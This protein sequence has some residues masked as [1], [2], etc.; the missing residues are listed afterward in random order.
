M[1]NQKQNIA[2]GVRIYQANTTRKQ[3]G[4]GDKGFDYNTIVTDKYPTELDFKTNNLAI[5][6]ENQFKLT[7]KFSITP[8]L[9]YENIISDIKGRLTMSGT[10][11]VN[12][13]PN[14]TTRS[15]ILGGLGLAYKLESTDFYANISQAF[16]PVLFS[17]ITPPATTDVIDPNLKDANGF[18]ADFG[19]R[20]S[21]NNYLTFDI[22]AFYIQYND[23]I[24]I[25]RQFVNNDSNKGTYQLRTNLG[26]SSNKGLEA[27]FNFNIFKAIKVNKKFGDLNLFSTMAFINATY[28][29]FKITT[30]SGSEPNII[31]KEDNLKGKKVENAPSQIHNIG[32]TYAKKGFSTTI[33]TRITSD[34]FTDATNTEISNDAATIG[35]INGYQVYDISVEYNF[36]QNYN[37]RFSANNFTNTKYATRRASGYPGP[38]LLPGE[39]RTFN[40][41]IGIKL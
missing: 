23:R 28:D 31:I 13:M 25:I 8:G 27:Y 1:F 18:N 16:R 33:Q 24:G 30:S 14:S 35:K 32:M 15:L 26:E 36:L 7:N 21:L 17:D 6:A 39:G 20:G 2:F 41:G 19:Y 34:V 40:L 12:A 37:I 9:R 29:D 5:F 38:G 11:D 4:K 22:S 3:K 10:N